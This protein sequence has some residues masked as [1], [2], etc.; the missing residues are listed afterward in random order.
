MIINLYKPFPERCKLHFWPVW[1]HIGKMSGDQ[2]VD[3]STGSSKV[4]SWVS[5]RHSQGAHE[6]PGEVDEQDAPPPVDHLQGHSEHQL[7]I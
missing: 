3:S 1:H 2:S 5:E 7:K 6:D 4:G